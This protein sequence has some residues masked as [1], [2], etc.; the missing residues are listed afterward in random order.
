MRIIFTRRLSA[1]SMHCMRYRGQGE[2][3]IADACI[4]RIVTFCLLYKSRHIPNARRKR[5]DLLAGLRTIGFERRV[6]VAF[7]ISADAV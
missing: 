5:D 3:V 4:A 2:R 6:T 1:I 7:V